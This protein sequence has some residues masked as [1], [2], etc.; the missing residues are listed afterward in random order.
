[1]KKRLEVYKKTALKAVEY[2]LAYQ[3]P[4][5]GYVWD[6]YATD[7]FHKQAYSWSL[8]G[9]YAQAHRLLDWVKASKLRPDGQ[10]EGYQGDVYKHSWFFQGAH[11]MGRFDL[12]YPVMSWL[13]TCQAPCG[14]F[15]HLDNDELIRALATAWTGVSAIYIGRMD[16]AEKAADCC[17]RMLEAQPSEDR[18]YYQMT[19]DG[20]L[21]TTAQDPDALHIDIAKPFQD[22]WEV[23]LQ[24][25]LMC[26]MYQATGQDKY[27]DLAG[28]YFEFKLR[29]YKDAYGWEGSGKSSLAAALYYQLTGDER[30]REAA[31]NYMDFLVDTQLPTGG[32][33][34]RIEPDELLIYIDHAAEF[35]IWLREIVAIFE[36][37][38]RN[39]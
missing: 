11:R 17:I 31:C 14:G 25:M 2:Q 20:K 37:K 4:D 34:A 32:W 29:C 33:R 35:S 5:G 18:F 13:A 8:W 23:G 24:M 3:Q 7:A 30:A 12:S 16:I 9:Y 36:S 15:P 38:T 22:Y 19:R 10:L 1:M 39:H 21:V 6:G 27:I 26:R 28:R